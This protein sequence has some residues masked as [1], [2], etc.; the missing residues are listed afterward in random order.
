MENETLIGVLIG[1]ILNGEGYLA[2]LVVSPQ[3]R[4]KGIA[5][6]LFKRFQE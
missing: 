4:G 6:R 2:I 5:K 3:H 1:Q